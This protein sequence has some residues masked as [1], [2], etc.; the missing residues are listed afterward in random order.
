MGTNVTT[1]AA[2]KEASKRHAERREYAF[3][4]AK[5][6]YESGRPLKRG[7]VGVDERTIRRWAAELGWVRG[8]PE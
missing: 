6:L 2:L 7:G 4:A 8:E 3:K 1:D 5:R